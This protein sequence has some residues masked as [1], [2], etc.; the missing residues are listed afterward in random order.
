MCFSKFWNTFYRQQFGASSERITLY[1]NLEKNKCFLKDRVEI[2]SLKTYIR[3][4]G[5]INILKILLISFA[6]EG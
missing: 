3:F 4:G 1:K 5:I 6:G 2:F